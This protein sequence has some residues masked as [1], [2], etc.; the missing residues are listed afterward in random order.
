MINI[1]YRAS[2]GAPNNKEAV[3][4]LEHF[5]ESFKHWGFSLLALFCL[6][7]QQLSLVF[8]LVSNLL[9]T[10]N[11]LQ[12]VKTEENFLPDK[13]SNLLGISF[14]GMLIALYGYYKMSAILV[15][16]VNCLSE[17]Y[18][19]LS[20]KEQIGA[21]K[22][23]NLEDQ[24]YLKIFNASIYLFTIV[25]QSK[26]SAA[27]MIIILVNDFIS[28]IRKNST[29]PYNAAPELTLSY[30]ISFLGAVFCHA[31]DLPKVLITAQLYAFY[32]INY[33]MYKKNSKELYEDENLDQSNIRLNDHAR[34]NYISKISIL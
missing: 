18:I 27:V 1:L 3:C 17:L 22:T 10:K 20:Y 15:F 25:Y 16:I 2:Q 30:I 29:G 28:K 7:S 9:R 6:S 21:K 34:Q 32:R 8:L 23:K 11:T 26:F 24:T 12:L 33:C 5:T 19:H 31:E 14:S 13:T 4:V